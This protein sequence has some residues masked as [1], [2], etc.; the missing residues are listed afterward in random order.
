MSIH[1]KRELS[2]IG[3]S[4]F[5]GFNITQL[6]ETRY[7]SRVLKTQTKANLLRSYNS[8]VFSAVELNANAVADVDWNV[9]GTGRQGN[10]IDENQSP[11]AVLLRSVNPFMENTALMK[12]TQA[13]LDVAGCAF[14]WIKPAENGMPEAIWPLSPNDVTLHRREGFTDIDFFIF[15]SGTFRMEI[16]SEQIIRFF[17]PN[18]IEPYINTF[19]PLQAIW[20]EKAIWDEEQINALALLQ[21]HARPDIIV[22]SKNF[23]G[24]MSEEQQTQFKRQFNNQFKRAG[25]GGVFIASE[26]IDIS[27]LTFSSKD[28]ELLARKE[29]TKNDIANAFSVPLALLESKNINR[30]TLE[31]AMF[32]HGFYAIKPRIKYIQET[33]NEFYFPMF[34]RDLKIKFSDPVPIDVDRKSA[35]EKQDLEIGVITINEVREKRGLEPVIWG[36]EPWFPISDIQPTQRIEITGGNSNVRA[37]EDKKQN[38]KTIQDCYEEFIRY[39]RGKSDYAALA[40]FTRSAEISQETLD[41]WTKEITPMKTCGFICCSPDK[42]KLKEFKALNDLPPHTPLQKVF[43]DIFSDQ[44]DEILKALSKAAKSFDGIKIKVFP[45]DAVEFL[46]AMNLVGWDEET[47]KRARPQ[48]EIDTGKGV[49]KTI[50]TIVTASP[51]AA[52]NLPDILGSRLT[53]EAIDRQVIPLSAETVATTRRSLDGAVSALKRE[54][55]EG[56]IEQGDALPAMVK[57]VQGIFTNAKRHRAEAIAITES[58]KAFNAG[59][60][61]SAEQSNVVTALKWILSPKPCIICRTI[62]GVEPGIPG[63][64]EVPVGAKFSNTD[65]LFGE[66][67]HP[68]AHVNCECTL[69]LVLI[70][71]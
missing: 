42:E 55:R 56:L 28:A 33:L 31:A 69:G 30:A 61:L 12:L 8:I 11:E 2:V 63:T 52:E 5:Q 59:T 45:D 65:K 43:R 48:I 46:S 17:V 21:N 60:L 54:L 68:P 53:Q 70:E 36:D 35:M 47:A 25:A 27:P 64:P 37:L 71:F 38:A 7:N 57:R 10:P 20:K 4:I 41:R 15:Q 62:A 32:Q 39:R 24:Q 29:V 51:G 50:K 67:P 44:E 16:P 18:L 40:R 34:G 19:S 13:W 3:K 9:F 6:P 1:K 58:N 49:D 14:W 22:S 26:A 66:I 23:D